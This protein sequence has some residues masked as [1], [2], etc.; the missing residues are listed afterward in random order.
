M[1]QEALGPEQVNWSANGAGAPTSRL[2]GAL[3]ADHL[4]KNQPSVP[5]FFPDFPALREPLAPRPSCW[6]YL[7][8]LNYRICLWLALG[9]LAAQEDPTA[10]KPRIVRTDYPT[11][12]IVIAARIARTKPDGKANAS[13]ALQSAIDQTARSGGGVV[14]L[15]SGRY[16]LEQP[17]VLKEGVTLRGDWAPPDRDGAAKGTILMPVSGRGQADGPPAITMERGSGLREVTVWYPDQ[18]PLNIV[19]YPWTLRISTKVTGN[20]HTIL[21]VTLVNPYQAIKIGP[22]TNE[23]HLVR[24]VYGTPLKTGIW[25]DSTTDIGRLTDI[26]FS[27]HWWAR[28]GLPG[29]P[30]SAGQKKA[31]RTWLLANGVAVDIG[32]SDWEYMRG[33][34][35]EGYK[36]GVK[37]RHGERGKINAVMFRCDISGCRTALQL[38]DI[39]LIGLAVTGCRFAG[40]RHA[41]H[42]PKS[43][44][45]TANFNTCEFSAKEGDAVRLEGK[46]LLSF[47][48]CTFN[49]WSGNAVAASA[50]RVSLLGCDLKQAGTHVRLGA[51]LVRARILGNKFRGRPAIV[52]KS[53]GDVQITPHDFRFARPDGSAFRFPPDPRPARE[54]LF[55]VTDFGAR[56]HMQDNTSHFSKALKA[57]AEAGGGVVYVPAGR[58]Y[59][60]GEL[61][62]PSGVELRGSFDVPHHTM[63]GGSVLMV[64]SG[65]GSENGT[66]FIQLEKGS[67][68]RGLTVWYPDQD[69]RRV[70][71]YPWTVR[72]LG[73]KCWLVYVTIA[74][75]YQGVDLWTHPSDGHLVRYLAGTM[76]RRGLFISKCS[77]DGWVDDVQLNPH[78]GLRLPRGFPTPDYGGG[79]AG[80][81]MIQYMR[82]NLEGLVFGR[83]AR[84]HVSG[85]FLYAAYN[86]ITFRDDSGGPNARVL[87]H[88]TDTG[89]RAVVVEAAGKNGVQLINTQIVPQSQYQVG[90]IIVPGSFDDRVQ[91]FNSQIWG[92]N[93]S[94]VL[95]GNGDVLI[96]QAN[97]RTG[98]FTIKSGRCRIENVN[99][100]QQWRP[101]IRV[102]SGCEDVWLIGN[103]S[104]GRLLVANAAGDK[105]HVRAN[106]LSPPGPAKK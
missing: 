99:F 49:E 1:H 76:L 45:S 10:M 43:F 87:Q 3:S 78:Y 24:N 58:Y 22:E 98:P 11:E 40:L 102:G 14:F 31:L 96:Q 44:D 90:G 47:Q 88:G 64:R 50:G 66:P 16:R 48:N 25:N 32:R 7:G 72:G 13:H 54:Q 42:A 39:N 81:R 35:L 97:T 55:V 53:K 20:N 12:D 62:V 26:S 77:G 4:K 30:V 95:E 82:R 27:P 79:G 92:G 33:L 61:T 28:S 6:Y 73:P 46:G 15:P 60:N 65:R 18:D 83:C 17:I 56:T 69:V 8:M 51:A 68:L 80:G 84:E 38:D 100:A 86:G 106:S 104:P 74:N 94:G 2:G 101:H 71:P 5:R 29:S 19:P 89:S 75:A 23:L 93:V 21:N 57:A 91:F 59:F 36:A 41:V 34:H 9:L 37:L 52:N 63:S 103:V 67:G 105:C 85:T 70:T